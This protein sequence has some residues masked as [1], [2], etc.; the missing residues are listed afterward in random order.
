M[1]HGIG[2]VRPT[3]SRIAWI[4][5][6]YTS[7]NALP[8]IVTALLSMVEVHVENTATVTTGGEL[9]AGHTANHQVSKILRGD[10]D[11]VVLQDQSQVPSGFHPEAFESSLEALDWFAPFLA[12]RARCVLFASWG[13]RKDSIHD[14]QRIFADYLS[15]QEKVNAGYATYA[16]RLRSHGVDAVVAP[17]GEAFKRVYDAD[18][19]SGVDPLSPSSL[20][21]SLYLSDGSHPSV[22]GSYLAAC[23]IVLALRSDSPSGPSGRQWSPMAGR[24]LPTVLPQEVAGDLSEEDAAHLRHVAGLT[25]DEV[26]GRSLVAKGR[27]EEL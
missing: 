8:A 1:P 23:V 20:F 2:R 9:L 22:M 26:L 3:S 21:S 15:M 12:G 10:W 14:G 11:I 6:S 5:N 25:I 27:K 17:V 18:S 4:G 13:H 19:A 7:H 16:E 24:A